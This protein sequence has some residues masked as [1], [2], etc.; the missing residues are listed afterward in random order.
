MFG[1]GKKAG[2]PGEQ[3]ADFI[4]AFNYGLR[5]QQ[6]LQDEQSGQV[7]ARFYNCSLSSVFQPIV[8]AASNRPVGHQGL[9]RASGDGGASLSPWG[10]F[11]LAVADHE[12]VDLDRLCRTLHVLN[13]YRQAPHR[14]MLYLNV[15]LRL[16]QTV[17]RDFGRAF[18]NRLE[19]LGLGPGQVAIV[20]PPDILAH[21][22]LIGTALSDY[23]ALGY[24]VV[25]SCPVAAVQWPA[26]REVRP[27][28]IR[29]DG[30]SLGDPAAAAA[31]VQAIR[32]LGAL[33]LAEKLETG[34][35][36]ARAR[37][38]GFELLQGHAIGL[39]A[40]RPAVAVAATADSALSALALW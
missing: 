40:A 22:G 18:E 38:A 11:S 23:Q 26:F 3:I 37:T 30:R 36:V 21:P 24:R 20:L 15:Q 35:Q 33:G 25:V 34:D 16:L 4:P 5:N 8:H 9:L 32:A 28:V 31:V 29:I 6:L 2:T 1:S 13:F 19:R 10:V 12:L 39:P 14:D 27:D 7:T 17:G